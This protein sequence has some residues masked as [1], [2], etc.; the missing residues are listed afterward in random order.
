MMTFI[1]DRILVRETP[2]KQL[3]S[4]DASLIVGHQPQPDC[5]CVHE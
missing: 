4:S 3:F 2:G 1:R 5:R